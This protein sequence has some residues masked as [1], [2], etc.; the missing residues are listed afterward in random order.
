MFAVFDD[1]N[2]ALHERFGSAP[3]HAQVRQ[4]AWGFSEPDSVLFVRYEIGNLSAEPWTDAFLGLWADVDLG[5]A[6]NDR[7]A[8]DLPRQMGI[9][10]TSPLPKEREDRFGGAQPAL[11]IRLLAAPGDA[12]MSAFPLILKSDTE[13]TSALEA[14][15]LL[16]GLNVNGAAFFDS[17]A[18]S[19]TRHVLTGDP[20]SGQGWIEAY[21]SDKRMLISTGPLVV[22][23][24]EFV[25]L[26]I[27][28]V[29]ARSSEPLDAVTA[30]RSASD[31]LAQAREL[32]DF[33]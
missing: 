31:A 17:T 24:G 4:T 11:G 33:F 29:I 27:G 20:I 26:T 16:Q 18:Q 3:L 9:T 6:A 25:S 32:W 8:C 12:G 14:Y 13:P 19:T 22:N 30:L 7:V 10:Y 1:E 21:S 2:P 23:P 15:N 5:T 28:I